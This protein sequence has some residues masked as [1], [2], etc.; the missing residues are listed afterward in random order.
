MNTILLEPTDVLF[1]RDGRPMEGSLAGHGAG[2]PLPNVISAAFHAALHRSGLGDQA[3]AHRRGARGQYVDGAPRDRKFG[4]LATAGPFPVRLTAEKGPGE[5]FFPR[6]QDLQDDTLQ[7][8]L[9][10]TTRFDAKLSSLP[11]PLLYGVGNLHAPK[12]ETQAKTWLSK[13]AFEAYLAGK[14]GP[15]G[16]AACGDRDFSEV[17]HNI[18]IAID[19]ETGT[20]GQGATEGKIYSAHFLRLRP[21]WRLGVCAA[22]VDKDYS[23]HDHD[24]VRGLLNG[25]GRQIIVGGQQ[26][27]CTATRIETPDLPLPQGLS[28]GFNPHAGQFLLK[29]VLLSPA[30]WPEIKAD[31]A[32]NIKP[33]PGGWLPN[34]IEPQTGNVLLTSGP[35]VRKAQ[36]K[37]QDQGQAIAARLVAA[38]VPKPIVVTGWALP[39]ETDRPEGGAKSTH[40]AVPAGAV[41]YFQAAS[42]DA[43]RALAVALNWHGASNG[44]EIRNRRST[45]LG[46]KGFGL[47]VCG[48][49]C[50]YE[51][52]CKS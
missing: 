27:V 17:E 49:W 50:F 34:W 14:G 52:A 21:H 2:W 44:T 42:E 32:R 16:D 4:S 38:L 23:A 13:A 51:E 10:P 43:A 39:N 22:A 9:L 20:T 11:E 3:H 19:P 45:L 30:I 35:G 7:P 25:D 18:G 37:H 8:G 33:H 29:W 36:R 48:T 46:E 1:F 28:A 26:R 15:A 40:L 5:W 24:L 41:Y 31:P 47:G 6:P 12:K